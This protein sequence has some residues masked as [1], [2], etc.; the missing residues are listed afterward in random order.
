MALAG[1]FSLLFF[2]F[3]ILTVVTWGLSGANFVKKLKEQGFGPKR[4]LL[5]SVGCLVAFMVVI[6]AKPK[7]LV[8][9][10]PVDPQQ[11]NTQGEDMAQKIQKVSPKIQ[12]VQIT[13]QADGT[14]VWS[15][16][17][18][19][20]TIVS[21]IIYETGMSLQQISEKLVKKGL[22]QPFDEY[23]FFVNVP[24][25]DQY[26][27]DGE[28]LA[29]KIGWKGGDLL[30]VEWKNMFA[31]MFLNLASRVELRPIVR[32]EVAQLAMDPKKAAEYRGFLAKALAK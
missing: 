11:V 29:M 17:I 12:G 14:K 7:P 4:W 22:V 25:T 19:Q 9:L 31:P 8:S 32:A 6:P 20:G 18:K 10:E 23:L 21:D 30:K 28:G 1:L 24:T 16:I 3:L 13:E 5:L 15:L 2:L 26:G 27:R